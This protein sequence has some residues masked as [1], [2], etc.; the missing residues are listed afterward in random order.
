M[1]VN[2]KRYK[3]L[4]FEEEKLY[5]INQTLLPFLF[6]HE[7]LEN[8]EDIV[9]AIK[10]MIVRGAPLIGVTGAFGVYFAFKETEEK[11]K[12]DFIYL[13][14][15]IKEARPTAV[16]LAFAVESIV[17]KIMNIPEINHK[18]KILDFIFEYMEYEENASISIGNYGV[19]LIKEI[20]LKKRGETVNIL[21]HCNA[22]WLAAIDYGTALAPIYK[23]NAEGI[24]IHVWVDETRPRNQ[25]AK[26]T[27]WELFHENISHTVIVDNV[28]GHLMQHGMVDIVIVGCDRATSN[29]DAA[30]KIGT[31]LK[32]LAAYDNGVPFYVALPISTIDFDLTDG[33]TQIN[34]EERSEDEVKFIEGYNSSNNLESII[35]TNP[36]SKSL[37]IGFDVT[38]A[39]LI[40]AFITDNGI[41]KPKELSNIKK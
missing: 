27:A 39:R 15:K 24:N 9:R 40:T 17:S 7:C 28:G 33:I 16:N 26:L 36:E 6:K 12:E 22:G 35:I 20:S 10:E 21:T 19:E 23:A 5:V 3:T 29:G 30:N 4:Y 11:T 34:I 14:N 2:G 37:N 1:K 38:P 25:G 13:V 32:A 8:T 31:Y 41:F 18:E